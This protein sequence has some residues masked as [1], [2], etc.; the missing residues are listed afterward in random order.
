MKK[1]NFIILIS[2][3]A[4]IVVGLVIGLV[5]K[6]DNGTK[7]NISE[8]LRIAK[9]S[10]KIE[11]NY[12]KDEYY[13]YGLKKVKNVSGA[14]II[15]P[16]TVDGIPVT[17]IIDKET[18]FSSFNN[19]SVIKLGKNIVYIGTSG[20]SSNKYGESIFSGATSLTCIDVNP[21]NKVF[22][23]IDGVL[24]NK[25]KTILIKYPTNKTKNVDQAIHSYTILD[26]VEVIYQK[27]FYYNNSIEVVNIPDSVLTIE[28]QSFNG[29][30]RLYKINFGLN[31]KAIGNE[32]FMNCK[33]IDTIVLPINLE[34]LSYGVFKG[35]L[36]LVEITFN[37]KISEIG[38]SIFTGCTSLT[39]IY[40]NENFYDKLVKLFKDSN[41]T[42]NIDKIKHIK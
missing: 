1:K 37:D 25:E 29:C 39:S 24:Y 38:T 11:L 6:G 17:K 32:A 21:E 5:L 13:I 33:N 41:L 27:A 10:F 16:D 2:L 19:V 31:V 3:L 42:L 7:D 4:I 18:S 15:I 14:N 9:E 22:T 26:T 20:Y 30:S 36:K 12:N 34:K 8:E 40:V 28:E 23:S 35:C